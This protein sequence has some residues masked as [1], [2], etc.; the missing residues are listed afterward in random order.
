MLSAD[1][2]EFVY[3]FI[4]GYILKWNVDSLISQASC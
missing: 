1:G 4:M 3:L 2:S